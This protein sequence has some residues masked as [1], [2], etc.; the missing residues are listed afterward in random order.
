MVEQAIDTPEQEEIKK[1]TLKETALKYKNR[2]IFLTTVILLIFS[3][4][5]LVIIDRNKEAEI[6]NFPE[7]KSSKALSIAPTENV[8]SYEEHFAKCSKKPPAL[9]EP[10]QYDVHVMRSA[11]CMPDIS[12]E[13]I[14]IVAF[15]YWPNDMEPIVNEISPQIE[16]ALE[17]V[18]DF[19][20]REFVN[21][22]TVSTEFLPIELRGAINTNDLSYDKLNQE[23]EIELNRISQDLTAKKMEEVYSRDKTGQYLPSSGEFL[24]IVQLIMQDTPNGKTF[25][26]PSSAKIGIATVAQEIDYVKQWSN[27]PI[28]NL[29]AH[30]VGHTFGLPDMY[31][32]PQADTANKWF[33]SDRK[34]IMG[35]LINYAP[36]EEMYLSAKVK[37]YVLM[38]Q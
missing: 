5:F 37:P 13:K 36:L 17:K 19:W 33:D 7:S 21:K 10:S 29:I 25:R 31:E 12:L 2:I 30:E 27:V 38:Q 6:T 18:A 8:T 1:A 16:E 4:F 3:S 35:R 14:H 23:I 22:T 24:V 11:V 34:N 28:E 9:E 20:E 32:T 15:A 26:L